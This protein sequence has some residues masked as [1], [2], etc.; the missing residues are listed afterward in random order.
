MDKNNWI[1]YAL[2]V[3][4]LIG[5]SWWNRP[6]EEQLARQ[7]HYRD[8]VAAAQAAALER[9]QQELPILSEAG[10]EQTAEVVA[11]PVR[12]EEQVVL[13][14][15]QVRLTLSS[16]G[17]RV[18]RAELK[19][20]K[21]Y[22]DTVNDLSLFRGQESSIDMVFAGKRGPIHSAEQDFD[23]IRVD[24]N[25]V[26]MRMQSEREGSYID[27]SYTLPENEYMTT[28]TIRAHQMDSILD[29]NIKDIDL[30]WMQRIPQH[31]H[32]RDFENRYAQLQ[33]RTVGNDIEKLNEREYSAIRESGRIRWIAY[34]DQ[35]F[36]TVMIAE[37]G[38]NSSML[39]STPLRKETRYIKEYSTKATIDFDPMGTDATVLHVYYGPNHYKT[40]KA[41]NQTLD[42]PEL[43]EL[44]PLGWSLISWVNYLIVIPLFDLFNGWGLS[45]GLVILLLTLC[46]KL[47]VLPFVYKSYR[48]TAKMRVLRPQLEELNQR[49]PKPEQMQ[50][51]QMA[52]MNLYNRA[53]VS[54]MSGCLPMLL[55]MPILMAVFWF[56]PTAIELR[57]KGF[58]WADDLSTYDDIIHWSYNLPLIGDHLSLFCVLFTVVNIA[59]TYINMQQQATASDPNMKMMKYMMYAM[60]LMFFFW[61]NDYPAGLSYYY[62]LSL[63]ITIMQMMF[64]RW[65]TDDAKLLEQMQRNAAKRASKPKSRFMQKLEEMQRE[66]Q[67]IAREQ[68][69][70]AGRR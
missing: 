11:K 24:S 15:E 31:E 58:L 63:F 10:E 69:K 22:G 64:F 5:F 28:L 17:G 66:Q 47:I 27:L 23:I 29:T 26:I 46:I 16:K 57:G 30:A 62:L 56:F 52:T 68:A 18:V 37:G 9:A 21:S 49:Y 6:S 65:T 54:P 61:F 59:Y 67:R 60:P 50:E 70:K 7:K 3:A 55:Q 42:N 45:I 38:F 25:T 33:Y 41:Y 1:G 14:N 44:V 53:G 20:Y 39:K 51:K 12:E 2:I 43:E 8:S 36:S 40:L 19:Q 34:K 4:I 13:E 32:G 35:F 48:S